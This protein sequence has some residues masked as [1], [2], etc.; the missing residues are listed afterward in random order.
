MTIP[1]SINKLNMND[2][3]FNYLQKY[4]Y[5]NKNYIIN[6][7]GLIVIYCNNPN[8]YYQQW[9]DYENQLPQLIINI[10]KFNKRN[11]IVLRF[12]IKHKKYLIDNLIKKLRLIDNSIDIDNSEFINTIRKSYCIFIQNAQ[13]F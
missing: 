10:R 4:F 3:R 9:I 12:H 6:N 13:L 5:F 11:K 7:K 8:G 2:H 1:Y